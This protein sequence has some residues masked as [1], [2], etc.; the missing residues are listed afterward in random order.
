MNSAVVALPPASGVGADPSAPS[1]E[2]S[3]DAASS[4]SP[5]AC[6][7]NSATERS[8]AAGFAIPFP[9]MSGAEP[10]TGSKSR[11]AVA[12]A[13][14]GRDPEAACNV[15]GDVGEDVAEGVLR[16]EHVEPGRPLDEREAC[17]VDEH[18]LELD[19]GVVAGDVRHDLAPQ[20]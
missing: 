13:G 14:G 18:V 4:S 20:P 11:R 16:Q 10:W 15:G 8:I 17:G 12:E 3:R 6:R 7:S 1:T 19:V 9:A 5:A 2:R